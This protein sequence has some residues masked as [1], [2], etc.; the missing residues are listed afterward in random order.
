MRPAIARGVVVSR[1]SPGAFSLSAGSSRS[2]R[3]TASPICRANR[4]S[5]DGPPTF[6]SRRFAA[7]LSLLVIAVFARASTVME[8]SET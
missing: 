3:V 6:L 2:S 8:P 1:K 7:V 5:P 4:V